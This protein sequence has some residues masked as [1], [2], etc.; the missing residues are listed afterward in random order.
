[1]NLEGTVGLARAGE[2]YPAVILHGGTQ[3]ERTAAALELARTLLCEAAPAERPCGRCRHCRRIV[4]PGAGGGEDAD[5]FHPDFQVLLQ[6]LRTSTSVEAARGFLRAAQV[7]PFEARGQVFAVANAET[8]TAEAANSLLKN[9]EEPHVSAPRHFLLLAPSRLDLLPTL[10]SRSLALYLG[11]PAAIEP[12]AVEA[13]GRAFAD[14]LTRFADSGAVVYLLAAAD[15][16]KGGAEGW[17]EPRSGRPWSAA[18]ATILA[19]VRGGLVPAGQRR[20]VLALAEAL[21][22]APSLRVRSIG[23]ER[24]LE[25]LVARHLAGPEIEAV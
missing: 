12:Q 15:T 23:P 25:G 16:L 24:I 8:L 9:L 17:E 6:D 2:L 18:A 13:A 14:C 11:P 10:R 19:A 20:R 5:R 7:S 22:R 4:W 21:L 1:M 3:E